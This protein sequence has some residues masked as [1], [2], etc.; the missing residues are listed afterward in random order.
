[1]GWLGRKSDAERERDADAVHPVLLSVEERLIQIARSQT[2]LNRQ[3]QEIKNIASSIVQEL[4]IQDGAAEIL[5]TLAPLLSELLPALRLIESEFGV[6]KD[7]QGRLQ[8]NIN[9]LEAMISKLSGQLTRA[10]P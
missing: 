2:E 5:K 1:M 4:G 7:G 3:A 9:R 10:R 8:D 6:I